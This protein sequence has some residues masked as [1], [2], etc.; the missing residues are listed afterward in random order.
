MYLE[1]VQNQYIMHVACHV[2]S[3][4]MWSREWSTTSHSGISY[5]WAG[6]G[7][8][9]RSVLTSLC[10]IWLSEV[11]SK[12]SKA[13]LESPCT[14][15]RI[16]IPNTVTFLHSHLKWKGFCAVVDISADTSTALNW[17]VGDFCLIRVVA[18]QISWV[19]NRSNYENSRFTLKLASS[20]RLS[21]IAGL[22]ILLCHLLT[23][24]V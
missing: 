19:F 4:G 8:E 12:G 10:T 6:F 18:V 11:W 14:K 3:V 22:Y 1:R 17:K 24:H 23:G 9:E 7:H 15:S 20:C 2:E 16:T 5:S 13:L 21:V